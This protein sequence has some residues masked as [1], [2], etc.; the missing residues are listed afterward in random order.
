MQSVWLFSE[1]GTGWLA[2][3]TA[4]HWS[5]SIG[6]SDLE[7][8]LWEAGAELDGGGVADMEEAKRNSE[9]YRSHRAVPWGWG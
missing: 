5:P 9:G 8:V 1:N 7:N 4:P 2:S 3:L 6:Q